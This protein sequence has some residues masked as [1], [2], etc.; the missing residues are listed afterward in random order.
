MEV[1]E[2]LRKFFYQRALKKDSHK[3]GSRK[4]FAWADMKNIQVIYDATNSTERDTVLQYVERLRQQGKVVKTLAFINDKL[5]HTGLAFPHFTLKDLTWFNTINKKA[6]VVEEFL[7]QKPDLL[8]SLFSGESRVLTYVSMKS[9]AT[10]KIAP[11]S[12][13]G[14]NADLMFKSS[15]DNALTS[16]IKQIEL[17]V[18]KI[19]K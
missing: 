14:L 1:I 12:N 16:L 8:I 10:Y 6:T 7:A 17:F 3:Q 13:E 18:E 4:A 5:E 11:L 15:S 2:R 19:K 9:S